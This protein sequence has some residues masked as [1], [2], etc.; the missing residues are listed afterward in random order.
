MKQLLLSSLVILG[1]P[2]NFF[3]C[4]QLRYKSKERKQIKN[5]FG[6]NNI[7]DHHCIPKQWKNHKIIRDTHFDINSAS[8]LLFMPTHKGK[9]YLN[10][11]PNTRVHEGGHRQYN[12]FIKKE[13]DTIE[14]GEDVDYKK[15]KLW[16]MVTYLKDH[17]LEDE[18]DIPW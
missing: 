9:L 13:L 3:N 6:Y 7:Q 10:L 18:N 17:L 1:N 15:Y 2:R 14:K 12:K 16:I 8:N 4:Q 5:S 11:H